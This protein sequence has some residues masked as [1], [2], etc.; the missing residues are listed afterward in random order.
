MGLEGGEVIEAQDAEDRADQVG[1]GSEDGANHQH[2]RL[3]PDRPGTHRR[4]RSQNSHTI[5]RQ[6]KQ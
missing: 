2:E 4:K 5:G 6:G 1:S 3:A